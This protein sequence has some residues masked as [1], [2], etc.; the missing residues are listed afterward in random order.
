MLV[1]FT[2]KDEFLSFAKSG[3]ENDDINFDH[4]VP[5][6]LYFRNVHNLNLRTGDIIS[7]PIESLIAHKIKNKDAKND[8]NPYAAFMTFNDGSWLEDLFHDN[9]ATKE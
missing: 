5:T 8:K 7:M 9:K 4:Y 1:D 6:M 2:D 3:D